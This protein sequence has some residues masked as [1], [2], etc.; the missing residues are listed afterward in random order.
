MRHKRLSRALQ[1]RAVVI[2]FLPVPPS[3]FQRQAAGPLTENLPNVCLF[4][5]LALNEAPNR[6]PVG[7]LR[8]DT[9]NWGILSRLSSRV[10]CPA[11][12][13]RNAHRILGYAGGRD[14]RGQLAQAKKS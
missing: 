11:P 9:S 8:K 6:Y 2:D 5:G 12:C 13:E 1:E 10:V 4:N 7:M 14:Q 3:E